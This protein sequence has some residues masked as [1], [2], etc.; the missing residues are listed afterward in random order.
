MAGDNILIV[1]DSE[2]MSKQVSDTLS[3]HHGYVIDTVKTAAEARAEINDNDID[4]VLSNFDLPDESGTEFAASVDD[5]I[6]II[7]LTTSTLED[8]AADAIEAGVTE[9]VHKDNLATSTMDVLANRIDVA[10]RA[11]AN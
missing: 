2:F 7:L 6:P 9:F 10:I 11:E 1:E 5:E 3:M 8:I 4:C